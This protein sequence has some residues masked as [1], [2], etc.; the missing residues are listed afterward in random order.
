[1][2]TLI[3]KAVSG[4]GTG[5][6]FTAEGATVGDDL[7]TNDGVRAYLRFP[8]TYPNTVD[9]LLSA[10]IEQISGYVLHS[11]ILSIQVTFS[12]IEGTA[13]AAENHIGICINDIWYYSEHLEFDTGIYYD[14]ATNPVTLLPWTPDEI[15]SIQCIGLII[16]GICQ[17]S[18]YCDKAVLSITYRPA[19]GREANLLAFR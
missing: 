3:L 5:N 15:N 7:I 1:M 19:L 17:T 2:A 6:T 18:Y 14:W 13:S 9:K 12:F 8:G 10:P 11:T 16:H 4:T